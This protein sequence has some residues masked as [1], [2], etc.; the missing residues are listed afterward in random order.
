LKVTTTLVG[1]RQQ[2]LPCEP[3]FDFVIELHQAMGFQPGVYA[4][5]ELLLQIAR[6]MA[7][8]CKKMDDEAK[9]RIIAQLSEF[10][11]TRDDA[12]ERGGP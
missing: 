6:R 5:P 1:W 7:G 3:F 11:R 4:T 10:G 12:E 8:T 9:A 2:L